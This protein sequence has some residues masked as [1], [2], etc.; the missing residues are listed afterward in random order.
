M[1]RFI[2]KADGLLHGFLNGFDR[3][4][5]RGSLRLLSYL[6]GMAYFMSRK[7]LLMKDFI[8]WAQ[9]LSERVVAESAARA[10]R[11]SRPLLYLSS[12]AVSK[13][14]YAL[15]IARRDGIREGLVCI[16]SCVEP[17]TAYDVFRNRAAKTL[18][19]QIRQRKCLHHYHYLL[20]PHFGLCHVRLQTWVPFQV[21]V[22]LHGREW[23]A[24]QMEAAGVRF[25]KRDN[26]FA[27]IEDIAKA[28]ALADEQVRQPWEKTLE[29]L[30]DE[31]LPSRYRWLDFPEARYYWSLEQSEW[32]TD[33]MYKS[34]A[35]LQAVYPP[36]VQHALQALN[37]RD[38]LRFLGR[39]QT[40]QACSPGASVEVVSD[41][42]HRPEG[43]RLRHRVGANSVKMYDKQGS[44]LRV[45]TT[46]NDVRDFKEKRTDPATG[47]IVW[48]RMRKGVVTLQR[49]SEISQGVNNR[50]LD[51]LASAD[52]TTPVGELVGKLTKPVRVRGR[53][54]RAL[55][56]WAEADEQ[57]L[58]VI[59]SGDHLIHGLRNRDL[60]AAL[61]TPAQLKDPQVRRKA[62][63][64][65]SRK[66][67]LLRAHGLIHKRS[68]THRYMLSPL[69]RDL[70]AA[71][72]H[73]HQQT[74]REILKVA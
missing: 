56:P 13:E 61:Y 33:L 60:R 58:R 21:R 42:K 23:L 37:C 19:L 71:V 68:G 31:L 6:S 46:I 28:Q 72:L 57:L 55:N 34:A 54:Y 30:L 29:G 25:Q 18:D 11:E 12:S 24:R 35:T 39:L 27:W 66:L 67:A 63:A 70:I 5:F 26:C 3:M 16:L 43:R 8:P 22:C 51:A 36:L 10:Q 47:K 45:E 38:V 15:D 59:G 9:A 7:S 44:V 17:C 50:Y 1:D 62:C 53:R 64:A 20:H 74:V 73:T 32:A 41:L 49:R 65:V 4:L 52:T 14:Q 2:A 48:R 40:G 69:G